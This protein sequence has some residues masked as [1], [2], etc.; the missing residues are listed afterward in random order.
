MLKNQQAPLQNSL[1]RLRHALGWH[2]PAATR[3]EDTSL[4]PVICLLVP[5]WLR[6]ARSQPWRL[7]QLGQLM[8]E[9]LPGVL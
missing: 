5:A 3:A 4:A 8:S 1:A 2:V 7:L 6:P 9:C